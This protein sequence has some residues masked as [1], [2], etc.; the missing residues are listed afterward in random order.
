VPNDITITCVTYLSLDVFEASFC[1]TDEDFEAR[2]RLNPVYDYAAR[3]WG[4]HVHAAST[5]MEQLILDFLD[6][7]AKVSASSQ[8]M[9]VSRSYY[10]Y[11]QRVP[12]Q[13]T[14]VH[15]ST[16][17]EATALDKLRKALGDIRHLQD[18]NKN[19]SRIIRDTWKFRSA[20]RLWWRLVY[21]DDLSQRRVLFL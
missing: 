16:D 13:M 7:E 20:L 3:H 17:E 1:P 19:L 8:A 6:N 15:K 21:L 14:G 11:S 2:S 9:M 4:H 10:G 5:E 12:R 18:A